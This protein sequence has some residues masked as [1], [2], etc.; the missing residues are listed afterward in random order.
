MVQ[1]R[2]M[3][4][5][6]L[7][8][9]GGFT[10]GPCTVQFRLMESDHLRTHLFFSFGAFCG[11]VQADRRW[12]TTGPMGFW[13]WGIVGLSTC[14]WNLRFSGHAGGSAWGCFGVL[15]RLT[16]HRS[17]QGTCSFDSGVLWGSVLWF[18]FW[19]IV[20]FGSGGWNLVSSGPNCAS[21]LGPC[22]VQ[23]RLMESVLLRTCWG[24]ASGHCGVQF[25]VTG[26]GSPHDH[27]VWLWDIVG[28]N[29]GGWNLVSIEPTGAS[30]FGQC[31]VQF[32][33]MECVCSGP[34]CTSVFQ[35]CGF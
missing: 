16:G 22:G 29:S 33:L 34:T 12:V 4:S 30:I 8:T 3:E 10:L 5:D 6:L 32:R 26:D 28:F 25:R 35:H 19:C 15:F 18:W 27:V 13:H 14:S 24:S 31:R 7:R 20:G 23:F 2:H 11:S 21:I 9:H 17:P 1:Y